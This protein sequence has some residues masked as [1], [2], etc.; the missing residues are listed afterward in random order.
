MSLDLERG[1]TR[2]LYG[3]QSAG[4]PPTRGDEGAH[5]SAHTRA[6]GCESSFSG[7]TDRQLQLDLALAVCREGSFMMIDQKNNRRSDA[8]TAEAAVNDGGAYF[9]STHPWIWAID[10][11]APHHGSVST[12]RSILDDLDVAFVECRSGGEDDRRHLFVHLGQELALRTRIQEEVLRAH[13]DVSSKVIDWRGQETGS[14]IR[15]PL[16]PHR[17][18]GRSE[19]LIDAAEALAV[20]QSWSPP[21]GMGVQELP[22]WVY[23][24]MSGD[25]ERAK[26]LGHPPKNTRDRSAIDVSIA[27]GFRNSGRSF[28]DFYEHRGPAGLYPSP[29]AVERG[30]RAHDYLWKQWSDAYRQPMPATMVRAGIDRL[31][32]L[33]WVIDWDPDLELGERH[34]LAGIVELCRTYGKT[35][36]AFSLRQLVEASLS[37]LGT[38]SRSLN[39]GRL[40]RYLGAQTRPSDESWNK[41]CQYQLLVLDALGSQ[42]PILEQSDMSPPWVIQDCST[43]GTPRRTHP[44]FANGRG[45]FGQTGYQTLIS[46]DPLEPRTQTEA[47]NRSLDV[48]R[49]TFRKWVKEF[50]YYGILVPADGRRL[51]VNPDFDWDWLS[52]LYQVHDLRDRLAD[53]HDDDRRKYNDLQYQR[54]Q[55]SASELMDRTSTLVA[56]KQSRERRRREALRPDVGVFER[57]TASGRAEPTF[58]HCRCCG[59]PTLD[60]EPE[61]GLPWHQHCLMPA[62]IAQIE[63]RHGIAIPEHLLR[64]ARLPGDGDLVAPIEQTETGLALAS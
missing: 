31:D 41:T 33:L 21:G 9:G 2:A 7:G 35:S 30:D 32:D 17:L 62:W 64:S 56:R 27:L 43:V 10:I 50:Q 3:P 45:V 28:S 52:E 4:T 58:R 22:S 6:S 46:F 11:D 38:V 48:G 19:P 12:L 16:A 1:A 40:S 29:K 51:V 61:T 55:I 23:A 25:W 42:V 57:A 37:S 63:E 24:Y 18:G 14:A 44:M 47:M 53:R 49:A 20:L 5:P 36:V 15:P 34:T 26:K 13:P 59:I 54:R 60:V 8:L 39:S